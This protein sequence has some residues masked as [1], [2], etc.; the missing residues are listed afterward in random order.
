MMNRDRAIEQFMNLVQ[1]DS[2]SKNERACADY[3]IDYFQKL[4]Y[5]VIE[6]LKSKEAVPGATAGNVIVRVPGRGVLAEETPIMLSTHMDTVEPGNGVKPQISEDG[7][8]IVT[9]GTTILGADDKG[10]IAQVIEVVNVLR[11]HQM[12]HPPL[13]L[14]FSICEEL[15]LLGATFID[16]SLIRAKT[17]YVLDAYVPEGG[18]DV[19][20]VIV[21][22]SSIYHVEGKIT[23]KAAHAGVEPDKGISSIQVLAEAISQMKL[24]KVDEETSSN[25]GFVKTDYPLNVV[26]EVTSFG[27]EVRSLNDEKAEMQLQAMLDELEQATN[28]YGATLEYETKKLLTAY[29]LSDDDVVLR[30]YHN[31]C[32]SEDIG[33][34]ELVTR[35]G[36]DVSA[37]MLHGLKGIVI[38]TGGSAPHTLQ[39][40][41]DIPT[42]MRGASLLLK[43]VTTKMA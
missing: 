17:V 15:G 41:L 5:E 22:S 38:T 2:V 11:E 30:H 35:A 3:L 39:E 36:T 1:I 19:G 9:D 16:M 40:Y 14:V 6:D 4:D 34:R 18:T 28:K 43:L 31:V 42:F 29:R 24:L 33:V 7:T 32:E 10:G 12:D 37:Y 21:G 20:D 25:V 26:P 23:G 8:R 13:E 27:F